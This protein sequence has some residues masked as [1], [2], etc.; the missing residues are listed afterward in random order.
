MKNS[1][2]TIG[3]RTRDLLTCSAV[4]QPTALRRAPL[5]S[6]TIRYWAKSFSPNRTVA[7]SLS[8]KVCLENLFFS[9]CPVFC[10]KKDHGA[11]SLK[12]SDGNPSQNFA[13]HS[14]A[15]C[16]MILFAAQFD[17]HRVV[18]KI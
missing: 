15:L 16:C 5:M 2:D 18:C 13:T 12:S 7:C 11:V 17:V 8:F 9:L 10:A 4:P 1:N 6:H 3:N 14:Y